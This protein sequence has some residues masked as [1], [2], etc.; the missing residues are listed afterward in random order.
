M[1]QC[2][3]CKQWKDESEFWKDKTKKDGYSASC[4]LCRRHGK[5]RY[6]DLIKPTGILKQCTSCKQWKDTSEFYKDR[7]K[8]DNLNTRCKTCCRTPHEF[9]KT[10]D[11]N[12]LGQKYCKFCDTWKPESEFYKNHSSKDGLGT[13]CK[14]CSR[15]YDLDNEE[16]LKQYRKKRSNTEQYRQYQRKYREEHKDEL[17][18]K[19]KER[20]KRDIDILRE[21]D[22]SRYEK[23]KLNRRLSNNIC[24]SLKGAKAGRHWEDLVP[25]TLQELKE[26]LESQFDKNMS[27]DNYGSYW[28]IDHIRPQ[29]TFN[30]TSPDDP[31][32]QI[33]WS[34]ANLRPLE[35]SL[36]RQRP[37]DGSDIKRNINDY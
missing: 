20:R 14:S 33:C 9:I 11:R 17:K 4:I 29:N 12:E 16:K 28:E 19:D 30:I 6:T 8:A 7:H 2:N 25:Y 34:L 27:W 15:Q 31:D 10:T 13:R 23:D 32:F 37:K 26:H 21:R 35:K 22:K 3:T 24:Q 18:Q 36:N 1:K 5:L